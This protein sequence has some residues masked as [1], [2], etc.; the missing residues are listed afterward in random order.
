MLRYPAP[1]DLILIPLF[2]AA[3]FWPTAGERLFGKI[4][5]TCARLAGR[6]RL[7]ILGLALAVIVARVSLLR[8]DPVPAP[9]VHDEFAHLLAGDTFAH[10]RLTNPPLPHSIGIFFET[11]QVNPLPTRMSK[12]PPGQGAVLA[13]GELLGCPWIGVLLS[14]AAMC[15]AVLWMLQGWLPA[16]WALLGAALV[17]MRFGFFNYW[18]D[19]YWGG[20]VA[21]TGGALVMGA[22]PRILRRARTRD[23]LWMGLGAFILANSRPFEGA[24]V[25]ASVA[26]VLL[27]WLWKREGEGWR[28][29]LVRFAVPFGAVVVLGAAFVGY[30]NWRV[31]GNA[32]LLPE[33]LGDQA[34]M[35]TPLF[36]W[37]KPKPEMHY[38]N[39]QFEEF[40]NEWMRGFWTEWFDS[41]PV[42]L[43][44]RL[45]HELG[46]FVSAY[47]WPEL[48]VPLLAVP[49]LL[50]DRKIRWVTAQIVV[51]MAGSMTVIWF[52]PHYVA[53]LTASFFLVVTEAM[54]RMRR[55]RYGGRP[56]GIGLTRVVVLFAMAAVPYH[57]A[58]AIRKPSTLTVFDSP[59]QERARIQAELDAMPGQQLV[60]VHYSEAHSPHEEWVYNGADIDREKV[61]WAREI[62]G[63]DI[64]PLLEYFRGRTVWMVEAD[65][66]TPRLAPY[67]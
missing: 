43:V 57:L 11:F 51:C 66:E 27:V 13:A 19:S 18:V 56:V 5:R 40:Y 63:V 28:E 36:L 53:P 4:E 6:K 24:L 67:P 7:V 29:K 21:A 1:V 38:L 30:D 9:T 59:V 44:V 50:R 32:W 47:A 54:R 2:I 41:G 37:Q 25:C 26:P 16:R 34:Y 17:W 64:E 31:T 14:V 48:C 55:W 49:C 62:P 15:A 58:E 65:Q 35:T 10:G 3:W 20:A 60:I 23:A 42:A 45:G 52:W 33:R 39:P 8:A 12:Y 22:L 46:A 61:V